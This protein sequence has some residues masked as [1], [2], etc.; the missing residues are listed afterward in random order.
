M[1]NS[2]RDNPK[3]LIF[4]EAFG[5][6]AFDPEGA[7]YVQ[8]MNK[9]KDQ[10]NETRELPEEIEWINSFIQNHEFYCFHGEHRRAAIKY[11]A[12]VCHNFQYF[13]IFFIYSK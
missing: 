13:Y 8:S 10:K 7:K 4:A 11:L 2:L 1:V 5:I 3:G 9:K 12:K 6:V